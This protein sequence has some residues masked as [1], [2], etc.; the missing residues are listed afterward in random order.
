L[1][2]LNDQKDDLDLVKSYK[3][4]S[5]TYSKIKDKIDYLKNYSPN[6]PSIKNLE[7]YLGQLDESLTEQENY[8][9]S[10]EGR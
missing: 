1:L 8:F 10:P 3:E 5:N 6:D 9:K 7:Q 2:H 4:L